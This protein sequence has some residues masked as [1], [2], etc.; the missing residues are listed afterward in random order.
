MGVESRLSTVEFSFALLLPLPVF[1]Q[2]CDGGGGGK[3]KGGGPSSGKGAACVCVCV[4]VW[5]SFLTQNTLLEGRAR[6]FHRIFASNL[7]PLL[8]IRTEA[9]RLLF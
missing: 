5:N 6:K 4:C 2:I 1:I 8:L 3:R 7:R 9:P